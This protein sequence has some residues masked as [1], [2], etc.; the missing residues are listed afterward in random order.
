[1]SADII[2]ICGYL[3]RITCRSFAESVFIYLLLNTNINH[4]NVRQ[5]T[6]SF[7]KKK[8]LLFSSVYSF[9]AV[10]GFVFLGNNYM[11]FYRLISFVFVFLYFWYKQQEIH[12][13]LTTNYNSIQDMRYALTAAIILALAV[14]SFNY[15]SHMI[16]HTY[17]VSTGIYNTIC[18]VRI[19]RELYKI[20]IMLLSILFMFLVYKLRFIKMKD[21]KAMS[22]H[23]WIPISFG[24]CLA[25]MIYINYTYSLFGDMPLTAQYRNTL[26]WAMAFILPSY[27]GFY[28]TTAQLTRLLS[29]KANYAADENIF[30]WTFN[31]SIIETTHLDV[32]DL[33]LF[34]TNFETN[35][36]TFKRKLKK[37]GINN[38]YKGYS[39]LVFCLILT[40]LYLGLKGWSFEKDIFWQASLVTD[41]PLSKLRKNI[42]NIIS[43]VWTTN[44]AET[45]IDGYYL[46][47]HNSHTYDQ[48]RHPNAEDFL[49]SIAK[50]V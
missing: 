47:Y 44:E 30:I 22:T 36:L 40:K 3:L 41:V 15:I 43:Q 49:M 18:S 35:K 26:L 23:K 42:D 31:P 7:S 27:I 11:N 12:K 37:L 14:H 25:S 48:K 13:N 45:L 46:P 19:F 29:I 8:M 10:L 1:M 24:F 2:R 4:P 39:E 34:M 9:T 32:Y 33:N 20:A 38:E 16:L 6:S 17:C 28:I 5:K 21:I 50:S